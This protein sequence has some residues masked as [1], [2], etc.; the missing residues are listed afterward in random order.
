MA[1]SFICDVC[2]REVNGITIV[3][4]MNFCAKCYQETFAYENADKLLEENNRLK[5]ELAE[6]K[7]ENARLGNLCDKLNKDYFEQKKIAT[8]ALKELTTQIRYQKLYET[9]T[10]N[11]DKSYLCSL[12][13]ASQADIRKKYLNFC[14]NCGSKIIE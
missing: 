10:C 11:L 7:Q 8:D 9:R 6:L 14:S 13:G 2:G 1:M 4:G 3:N 12:C 5:T